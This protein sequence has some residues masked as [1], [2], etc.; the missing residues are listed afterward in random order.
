MQNSLN[1]P[2]II[3]DQRNFFLFFFCFFFFINLSI[4]YIHFKCY[5]L[6]RF[7]GKHPP[8]PSPSLWVFPSQPSPQRNF[9]LIFFFSFFWSWELNPGL[10]ACWAK[11]PTPIKEILI[12]TVMNTGLSLAVQGWL[13][14]CNMHTLLFWDRMLN[15]ICVFY[16]GLGYIY[17]VA[18]QSVVWVPL[19]SIYFK[20]KDFQLWWGNLNGI[21]GQLWENSA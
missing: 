15:F 18:L 20:N 5:S 3:N 21:N 7:P 16:G 8:P 4:S 17:P 19:D 2:S 12:K 9:F 1:F 10:C 11:S 6:S 13:E 14:S